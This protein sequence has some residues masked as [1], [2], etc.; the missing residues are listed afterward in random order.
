MTQRIIPG[1]YPITI[2]VNE[3]LGELTIAQDEG[4]D[5]GMVRVPLRLVDMLLA[6]IRVV[7]CATQIEA[8]D[9]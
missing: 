9:P 8:V 2:T 6:D 3:R 1:C 5:G 7:Y 4:V